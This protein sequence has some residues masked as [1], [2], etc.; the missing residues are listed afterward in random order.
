MDDSIVPIPP[1]R[2][3]FF[4]TKGRMLLPSPRSVATVLAE[5]PEGTEV[6]VK[7]LRTRLAEKFGVEAVCPPTTRKAW[8]ALKV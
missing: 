5:F 2:E 8:K 7:L 6:T 4:G 1:E 3:K